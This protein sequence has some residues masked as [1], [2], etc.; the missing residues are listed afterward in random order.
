MDYLKKNIERIKQR[1]EQ[2]VLRSDRKA[3][4][5]TLVAVSKTIDIPQVHMASQLGIKHFG[6]NR[7]QELNRKMEVLPEVKWHMIGRVQT[8]KVK[9][10][11]GRV[12]LL[13]SLDRWKLAEKLNARAEAQGVVVQALLQV[14]IAGEKQKA[15]IEAADVEAFLSSI[16]ELDSLRIRGLMTMAPLLEDAEKTRPVFRGLYQLKEKMARKNYKNVDL[17]YLS[18]G[19]SQDFEIAIEEG[20][21]IVRI[22]SAIFSKED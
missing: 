13:H 18:M 16:G 1:I 17:R 9:D 5:I 4:D 21:N 7:V 2:A 11:V 22:G 8:N 15:G 3:S 10:I 12:F 20:A 6:E 14:N 19:M